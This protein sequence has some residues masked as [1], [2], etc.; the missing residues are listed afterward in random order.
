MGEKETIRRLKLRSVNATPFVGTFPPPTV[1][2]TPP[3]GPQGLLRVGRTRP[4]GFLL[5]IPVLRR[6]TK[7]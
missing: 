3:N 4:S 2:P 7:I 6:I 1:K 5:M